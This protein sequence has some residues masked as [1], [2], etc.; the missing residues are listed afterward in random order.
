MPRT[1]APPTPFGPGHG[2]R[3]YEAAFVDLTL[4]MERAVGS[5]H[6]VAHTV[7]DVLTALGR[8][9]WTV[10]RLADT[11]RIAGQ[12]LVGH[13]TT[14]RYAARLHVDAEGATITVSDYCEALSGRSPVWLA[15]SRADQRL[16]D[17]VP[18]ADPLF[19]AGG[20]D[21]GL[22]LHRTLDGHTRIGRRCTWPAAPPHG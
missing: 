13:T 22:Q 8:P 17:D 14:A 19:L 2:A 20:E 3:R 7:H 18:P 5:H 11:A 9:S 10:H 16:V 4:T 15:V 6:L 1:A 21:S 12:Y